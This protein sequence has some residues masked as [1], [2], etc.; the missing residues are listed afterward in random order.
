MSEE[1]IRQ[2]FVKNGGIV[3]NTDIVNFFRPYL[4]NPAIKGKTTIASLH[5]C[6]FTVCKISITEAIIK[7]SVIF[8]AKIFIKTAMISIDI[9]FLPPS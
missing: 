4:S 3:K 5:N 1:D 6:Y 9:I 7:L 8:T 2:Y